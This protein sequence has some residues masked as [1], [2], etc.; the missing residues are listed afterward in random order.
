MKASASFAGGAGQA[1]SFHPEKSVVFSG[2][3]R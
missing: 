2:D 3:F 1:A